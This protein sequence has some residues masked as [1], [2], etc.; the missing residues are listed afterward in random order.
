MAVSTMFSLQ[1][2]LCPQLN[3]TT[4]TFIRIS[5]GTLL[6]GTLLIALPH[7]RRF[8]ISEKWHGYAQSRALTDMIQ[9]LFVLPF[10]IALWFL[11][12]VFIVLGQWTVLATFINL[13]LCRYFF[14]QMRW[15]GILR[16]MGAPGFMTYWL[17]LA[18]FLLEYSLYY[19]FD[20]RHL[21]L[22]MLQVDFALIIFSAGI[23]KFTA[24]YPQNQGMEFGLVNPEWGYW[25]KL[26]SKI[27]PKH[28]LFKSLNQLAWGTEVMAALM[29][30][31]PPTRFLGAMLII[32]SF[33]FITTQIRL[34]LL[35]EM[36]MICGALYFYPSSLGDQ[37]IASLVAPISTST[38]TSATTVNSEIDMIL[39]LIL[40]IYLF[41]L[42][43]AHGGLFY[44]FYG[45]KSLPRP[46]QF[47]LEVYTNFF[48]IIIWRVFSVDV[49]NFFINIYHQ[50]RKGD[51][52]RTL[53]SKWGWTG[54]FRY[55]HVGESITVTSIFTSL[56]YY[57]SNSILFTER[58]LR[59]AHTISCPDDSI[60]IFEYVSIHKTDTKFEF[61]PVAEYIVDLSVE[62][63][64]EKTLND[65]VSV[66]MGHTVSPIH[67]GT[68]PGSYTP[69]E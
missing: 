57:P 69:L 13:I 63:V 28:W 19:A 49:V 12:A 8:F 3:V 22:L 60:L 34:G 21:V 7:A 9:N 25:W 5:Y 51:R 62:K 55:G 59:Y 52:E 23:Y 61:V 30:L 35:C 36:V 45:K 43:F 32:L 4:Q 42:P 65:V 33:I 11:C 31:I 48:G 26:Y 38:M 6:F 37:F 53:I 44:N 47:I 20:M 2:F 66:R 54:G 68:K 56:K 16:G 29:M 39:K 15:K 46:L 64:S 27:S 10:V 67:E 24:G 50:P 18:I 1:D 17:A 41:L 58:L 14:V 40:W